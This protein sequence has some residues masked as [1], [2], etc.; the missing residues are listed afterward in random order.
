MGIESSNRESEVFGKFYLS[1][2]DVLQKA[3]NS[4]EF[5]RDLEMLLHLCDTM[6]PLDE[7]KKN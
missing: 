2:I 6:I 4:G 3:G 7:P 1:H 5:K